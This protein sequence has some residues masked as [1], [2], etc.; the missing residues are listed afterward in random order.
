MT[1]KMADSVDAANLPPGFDLYAGYVDGKF[2]NFAQ[3]E[4]K[5]PGKS[6]GIAVFSTT[7][8]G[9]VGDCETGD[10][11]P[12]TAVTWVK[13]RRSAGVNPT[14]YCSESIWA[15]V[16]AAFAAAKVTEPQWWIAGYPGSVGEALYPGAVAHQWIDRGPYDE[17]IVADYWPG[18]DPAPAPPVPVP[19][20]TT[21]EDEMPD[22]NLV[23]KEN[24]NSRHVFVSEIT[25]ATP[26]VVTVHH[27]TQAINGQPNFAWT[28][29][30]LGPQT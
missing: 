23:V 12:Q 17:S 22:A 11:T 20:P 30:K 19:S 21:E 8:D 27:W 14:I 3:V 16:K 24:G 6:L 5:Y 18:V 25:D 28:Y 1:R 2:K 9:I 26:P 15:A 4:A 7:N 13:T 29:E 10:M